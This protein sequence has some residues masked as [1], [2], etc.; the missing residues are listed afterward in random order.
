VKPIGEQVIVII[1]GS[2]GIG[3]AT[4][5]EAARQ[6][7]KVAVA[8]RGQ[9]ALNA[10]AAEIRSAGGEVLAIPCDVSDATQVDEVADRV[11]ASW[12]GIDTWVNAAA[13][14]VYGEFADI[15]EAEFRRVIEVDILG[16]ANGMRTAIGR[17]RSQP[18]GGTIVN[19]S[20]GLGDRAVPLQS[21]YCAAKHAVNGLS[22]A[23]RTE[24]E[25]DGLPIRVSVIKPASIDTPFFRHAK[26]R[27]DAAPKP[28]P[29]VYDPSLVAEAI[30]YAA[31]HPVRE[32]PV[33]G[34]SAALSALEK[35]SP[36]L[37]DLQL[38]LVGYPG[39]RDDTID[40]DAT[41]DNLWAGSTGPGSVEGGYGGRRVSLY[42]WLRLTPVGRGAVVAGAALTGLALSRQLAARGRQRPGVSA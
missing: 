11:V 16:V 10:A 4:G 28:L 5:V 27:M 23:V 6:G 8:A 2:S 34:A 39:Q 36:R 37:L 14:S 33:G 35:I 17:M 13:V 38:R 26:S 21:A 41:P 32:L 12:G 3:R 31:V 1:G 15:P 7:A 18:R 24:L 9:E 19:V 29:P 30:L 22:E 20:S 25:H 40:P 42:S